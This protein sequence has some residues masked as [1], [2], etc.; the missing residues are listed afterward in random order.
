MRLIVVPA[1]KGC[2]GQRHDLLAAGQPHE[3]LKAS[4]ARQHLGA[5]TNTDLESTLEL[6]LAHAYE[7]YE[8]LDL[9]FATRPF[10]VSTRLENQRIVVVS[11]KLRKQEAFE[12]R[13]ALLVRRGV[14]NL[15]F[16]VAKPMTEGIVK[17]DDLVGDLVKR[18]AKEPRCTARSEPHGNH[19]NLAGTTEH[20][21][22][23]DLSCE[24]ASAWLSFEPIRRAQLLE[25]VAK[26][27][28]QLHF[29]IRQDD[30]GLRCRP[31]R[32]RG[33]EPQAVDVRL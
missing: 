22:F 24:K 11:R 6:T 3:A 1:G 19:P 15:V 20:D 9:V 13:K 27:D 2:I 14:E 28:D 25:D 12:Q 16:E 21:A 33:Q 26:M 29:A 18:K 30:L 5:Q 23:R 8:I 32:C 7:T 4:D 17:P 31:I 10:D